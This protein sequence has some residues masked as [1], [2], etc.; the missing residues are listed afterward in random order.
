[1]KE[2]EI[3]WRGSVI[4]LRQMWVVE[5]KGLDGWDTPLIM[6]DTE[7]QALQGAKDFIK[8]ASTPERPRRAKILKKD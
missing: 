6:G 4:Y 5:I 2:K 8:A 3:H 1:M 7:E